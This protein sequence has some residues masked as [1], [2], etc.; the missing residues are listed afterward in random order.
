MES[1]RR[2]HRVRG[3]P[4]HAWMQRHQLASRQ[5]RR[6]LAVGETRSPGLVTAHQAVLAGEQAVQV[7]SHPEV[8]ADDLPKRNRSRPRRLMYR[9]GTSG[10]AEFARGRSVAA[11]TDDLIAR[12]EAWRDEDPDPDTRA[13]LQTLIDAG[14]QAGLADR[15][16]GRLEFGTAGLRGELGAGPMRMN[17]V[18]VRRAAAGLARWLLATIPDAAQRGVVIGF[19]AR[20]NSD[21]F[22][23]DSAAVFAGAGIRALLMPHR[24]PTP[25]LAFSTIELG[26]AAGVMVTASHNP[27]RDNGYKVYLGDGRQIV[28]PIDTEISAAI[29]A[30]GPLAGVPLASGDDPLI[31]RLDESPI[32]AYLAHVPSVRLVPDANDVRIAYTALHGVGADVALAAFERAGLPAPA[33]VTAQLEPDPEFPG[34][35]FPNPEEPGTLDLLLAEAAASGADIAIANDPDADRLGAAI[36]TPDGQWRR[37]GGDEI[38]WLLAEH[39]LGHT[40]GADRL[41]VTTLVSSALL[42]RLAADA[43]VHYA[44]TFTGFKWIA[45]TVLDHPGERFVFGYEQALGYLVTDRPLDKDGITAAVLMAEVAAVARRD[46]VTLQD[47]LDA[48]AQRYGRHVTAERSVP[49]DPAQAPVVMAKLRANPPVALAGAAVTRTEEFPAAGLIRFECGADVRVQIRPSG[50]EPKVKI[51]VEVIDADPAPFLDAAAALLA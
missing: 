4:E 42:G 25:V 41:V 17:R 7:V 45:Q 44:E 20:H 10:V 18:V 3:V 11:V 37:L 26:T 29:D 1:L 28:T 33:V 35:P 36:A 43:G 16:S 51:Y 12:A 38:G 50:T 2:R 15:F 5:P 21:V 47:R 6:D 8:C 30:V 49:V 27:R 13:E 34:L 19:D 46:G 48:L 14:D 9:T 40:E 39:I 32:E 23:A 22:A 31:V 24:V